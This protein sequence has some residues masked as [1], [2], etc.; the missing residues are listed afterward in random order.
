MMSRNRDT[1]KGPVSVNVDTLKERDRLLRIPPE[2]VSQEWSKARP[3]SVYADTESEGVS[4][5]RDTPSGP[6]EAT[7]LAEWVE[8]A[9]A[10]FRNF[11]G[12][13]ISPKEAQRRIFSSLP[14]PTDPTPPLEEIL[15]QE[16][17]FSVEEI[18]QLVKRCSPLAAEGPFPIQDLVR[19]V[20]DYS[21]A[22]AI[23][24]AEAQHRLW[25]VLY[26]SQEGLPP[27]WCHIP[28][29]TVAE[30][31]SRDKG[32]TVYCAN[33]LRQ[34]RDSREETPTLVYRCVCGKTIKADSPPLHCG[35]R[36]E[37]K[38]EKEFCLDGV[39]NLSRNLD[40]SMEEA[41]RVLRGDAPWPGSL[42]AQALAAQVGLEAA[43][44]EFLKAWEGAGLLFL[45]RLLR[46]GILAYARVLGWF[47]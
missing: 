24:I 42:E 44:A 22:H 17:P 32:R 27:P 35:V 33:C 12:Y 7:P 19:E 36:M 45:G 28:S 38:S 2:K 11:P 34:Q 31:V 3:L 13:S 23:S 4:P 15:A 1:Q 5:D 8:S 39:E 14:L 30:T 26:S 46:R 21:R 43:E 37:L 47:R 18:A 40:I 16:Y 20:L 29:E 10:R 9:A 6:D 41:R 25:G